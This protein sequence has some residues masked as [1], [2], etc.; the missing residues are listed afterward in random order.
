MNLAARLPQPLATLFEKLSA[1][2][3]YYPAI[4][5]RVKIKGATSQGFN[6][7]SSLVSSGDEDIDKL[8]QNH[9]EHAQVL[10]N[11]TNQFKAM[12]KIQQ[13]G[14]GKSVKGENK[15]ASGILSQSKKIKKKDARQSS[16]GQA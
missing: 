16:S 1:F 8:Y 5:M 15:P 6:D 12:R 10:F 11:P 7:P 14:P 4:D 2:A 13:K 9:A 3:K